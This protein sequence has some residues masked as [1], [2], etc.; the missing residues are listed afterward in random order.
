MNDKLF[1][2]EI[3]ASA[4]LI[5]LSALL[6]NPIHMWMPDSVAQMAALLALIVF[7]LFANFVWRE[8]GGDERES[9]HRLLAA[10]AAYLAGSGALVLGI[11]VQG[12]RHDVDVWLAYALAVMLAAKALTLFISRRER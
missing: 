7:V 8:H 4:M 2:K 1:V 3:I 9:L 5:A 10:R 6:V 12:L 11:I